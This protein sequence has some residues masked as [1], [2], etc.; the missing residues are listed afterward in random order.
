MTRVV[1][2]SVV[3]SAL[4][5]TDG[6]SAWAEQQCLGDALVAPHLLPVEVASQLR[7]SVA[8]GLLPQEIAA[9]ALED[10]ADL[11]I[12][13]YGAEPQLGRIWELRANLTAYG[14]RRRLRTG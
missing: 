11:A 10:L 3:I 14:G 5:A 9:L 6:R 2:A 7:R 4:V 12:T 13:Y 1:D 8:S